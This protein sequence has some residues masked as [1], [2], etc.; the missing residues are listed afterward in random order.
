MKVASMTAIA[1]SQG[2]PG[3]ELLGAGC[4]VIDLS[5]PKSFQIGN[6]L[7][8]MRWPALRFQRVSIPSGLVRR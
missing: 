6:E 3:A 7:L 5:A 1:T 4:A 8:K 2:L